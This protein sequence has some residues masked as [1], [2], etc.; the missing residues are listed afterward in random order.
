MFHRIR[1][2]FAPPQ[3]GG[4]VV[5][6]QLGGIGRLGSGMGTFSAT[7]VTTGAALMAA[8]RAGC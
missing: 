3:G 7:A 8:L 1:R 2:Q 6:A 4:A 5:A